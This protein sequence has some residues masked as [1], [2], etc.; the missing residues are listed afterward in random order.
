MIIDKKSCVNKS[1]IIF[2]YA[3][4]VPPSSGS[5]AMPQVTNSAGSDAHFAIGSA[6]LSLWR[7]NPAF[8]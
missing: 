1:S 4:P 6:H 8:R 2:G 3:H 5:A 7:R